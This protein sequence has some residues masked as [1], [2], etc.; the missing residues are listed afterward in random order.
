MIA[1]QRSAGNKVFFIFLF[2]LTNYLTSIFT[3][4]GTLEHKGECR[5][6]KKSVERSARTKWMAPNKCHRIFFVHWL[7]QVP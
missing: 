2:Y 4:K 1:V 7:G 5:K 6:D 3:D